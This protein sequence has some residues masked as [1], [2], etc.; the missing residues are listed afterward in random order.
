MKQGVKGMRKQNNEMIKKRKAFT[1]EDWQVYSFLIPGAILIIL[2]SY[3]P[4]YGLIM[5]FQNYRAGDNIFD[6]VNAKW[7][8]L[9]YFKQYLNSIYFERT[10]TNTLR[11]S[12]LNLIFGFTMPIIFALLLNEVRQLRVKKAVQTI[13]YLPHFISTVVVAGMVISFT[14]MNGLI[15]NFLGIFGVPAQEWL[16]KAKNFPAIYT[17]TNVWKGFGFGSILYFSSLSSIDPQMYEAARIDGANRWQQMRFI[18]LPS[19]AFII[20]VQLVMK[21]GQ[22][23]QSN[24]DLILLLYR[25]SNATMSD[26]ISTYVYRQG[27]EGGKYSLATAVGFFSSMISLMLTFITNKISNRISGYGLW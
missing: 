25:S 6:L 3:I 17:V 5:A 8:G 16:V 26:T 1:R 9:K 10:F 21:T 14:D 27:I 15:N 18:T 12:V 20:A 2:F 22:M 7:V 13:S 4:M 23:L 19:L 11:L 24:R